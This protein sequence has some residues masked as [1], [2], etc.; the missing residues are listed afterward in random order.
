MTIIIVIHVLASPI[1]PLGDPTTTLIIVVI[2][3]HVPVLVLLLLAHLQRC[4][5][6]RGGQAGDHG[7]CQLPEEPPTVRRPGSQDSQGRHP[8]RAPRNGQDH[9]GQSYSWR[10]QRALHHRVGV[11]VSGDVRWCGSIEGE[12]SCALVFC[13]F[14]LSHVDLVMRKSLKISF[15]N[16][17]IE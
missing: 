1:F 5:W 13:L 4:G 9:A 15:L 17:E 8:D 6:L 10:G 12:L 7:V 16:Q 11:R 3:T 2:V 14:L